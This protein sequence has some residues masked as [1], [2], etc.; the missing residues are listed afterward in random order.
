MTRLAEVSDSLSDSTN[1]SYV[2]IS[3]AH[4][5]TDFTQRLTADL[6][7]AGIAVWMDRIGL[8]PGMPDWEQ[9]VRDAIRNAQA[10]ILAASRSRANRR[11]CAMNWQ[12]PKWNS[13]DLP[14]WVEG[15]TWIDSIP[16]GRG[17]IQFIDARGSAYDVQ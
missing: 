6:R 14:V 5:N 9:S 16:L 1:G 12:S 2:F 13:A 17:Y 15:T 3:Y 4:V 11:M 8:I 7:A 10:V